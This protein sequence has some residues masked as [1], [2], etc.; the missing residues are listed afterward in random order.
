MKREGGQAIVEMALITPVLMA[1]LVGA[2][3]VGFIGLRIGVAQNGANT[4]AE[5]AARDEGGIA[6]VMDRACPEGT[7]DTD[8]DGHVMTVTL[9]CP[10]RSITTLLPDTI[11]V[12]ASAAVPP[13]PIPAPTWPPMPTWPP[14]PAP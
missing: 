9:R 2:A 13:D 3:D 10:Y 4:V 7:R 6:D 8:R 11:V 12:K 1:L 5:L 14:T